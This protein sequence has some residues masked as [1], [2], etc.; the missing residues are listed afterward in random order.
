MLLHRLSVLRE[1]CQNKGCL[2]LLTIRDEMVIDPKSTWAED[3][4]D[5][6]AI[7]HS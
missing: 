2:D 4:S 7:M 3:F 6:R 5:G 1:A